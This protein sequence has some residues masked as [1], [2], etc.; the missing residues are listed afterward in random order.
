MQSEN[1]RRGFLESDQ[2]SWKVSKLHDKTEEQTFSGRGKFPNGST[3]V[4]APGKEEDDD[5]GHSNIMHR[6]EMTSN[7][8]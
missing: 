3:I 6:L 8:L 5:D 1:R 2:T 7:V 4:S